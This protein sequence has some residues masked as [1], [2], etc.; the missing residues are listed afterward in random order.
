LI[1]PVNKYLLDS[2]FQIQGSSYLIQNS[3]SKIFSRPFPLVTQAAKD[4]KK[5][6]DLLIISPSQSTS[7]R[8]LRETDFPL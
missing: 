1:H 7:L 4:A 2:G 5:I 6:L 8:A 3:K